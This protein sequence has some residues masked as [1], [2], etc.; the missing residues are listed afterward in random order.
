MSK[1][2]LTF[3]DVQDAFFN[4]VIKERT[5]KGLHNPEELASLGAIDASSF[6][7]SAFWDEVE[8]I[9]SQHDVSVDSKPLLYGDWS[10]DFSA[11][12]N[13]DENNDWFVTSQEI[14][15]MEKGVWV[16]VDGRGVPDFG[17]DGDIEVMERGDEEVRICSST[18]EAE[19]GLG[20]DILWK[21]DRNLGYSH[22]E[23]DRIAWR[24]I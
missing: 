15:E 23:S 19:T 21:W 7:A 22:N 3:E 9:E 8:S 5:G 13:E 1:V 11:E 4:I 20:V 16:Y 6:L 24:K 18:T 14:A 12:D 2:T 17:F 10:G